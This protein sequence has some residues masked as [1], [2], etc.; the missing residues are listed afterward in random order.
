MKQPITWRQRITS[1]LG[2]LV[3][4]ALV[5]LILHLF[6]NDQYEFHRDEL[7]TF[8]YARTLDWG[9]VDFPPLSPFMARIA[10]ELFGP[11][12]VGVRLIVALTQSMAMVLAGLIAR[13][14]GGSRWAQIVAALA[15]AAAPSSLVF[16]SFFGYGSFD[17]L[18]WVLIAYLVVRLLKSD[19]PRWWLA[20]GATI[21]LG[22]MT[23]YT[24]AFFGVGI[25]AGVLLTDARRYLRSP[26]LWGGVALAVVIFLPNAIWQIQ[27]NFISLEFLGTIHERDV[28]IGRADSFLIDQ[29]YLTVN[30]LTV[31]L[32]IAGLVYLFTSGGKRSRILG[33]MYAIAFAIFFFTQGRGY[34]LSGA[35]P[36]LMSAGAVAIDR[37]LD[38]RAASRARVARGAGVGVLVLSGLIFAAL[39]LPLAPINSGWWNIAS[40]VSDVLQEEIGWRGLAQTVA[41][42]YNSLPAD[43]KATAGIL[44]GNY[45]EAGAIDLYGPA[46][47]LPRAISGIN[48]YWLRGYGNPPP[49]TLVVL[50]YRRE[51]ADRFF[52][53]CE[54]K[55]P[56]TNRYGIKNEESQAYPGVFVCRRL[57]QPWSEFWKTL[58]HFG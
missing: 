26:W 54:L 1:D 20:I 11:S 19:N 7:A 16:S 28:R 43:E 57:R 42:V 22:M 37:W 55:S 38:S 33:W 29:F 17:Y 44:A 23:K 24:M 45:G 53:S 5:K 3:L 32:W 9:Y 34:Y 25:V 12:I 58:R 6:I 40:S 10:L 13:E 51:I 31:P 35:Y 2:V 41:G 15:V 27:H 4:L 30:A 52:E 46:L 49:Q 14:L 48:T 8:D 36:M 39:L 21:G 56:V 50:G 47:G 18:W